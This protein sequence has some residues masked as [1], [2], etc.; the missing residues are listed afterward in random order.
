MQFVKY[1]FNKVELSNRAIILFPNIIIYY[2]LEMESNTHNE[3]FY[4]VIKPTEK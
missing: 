3:L 2:H 4:E 1:L